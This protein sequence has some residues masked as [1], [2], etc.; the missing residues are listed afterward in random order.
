[1]SKFVKY[2]PCPR[3][4]ERGRDRAGDNLALY[5]DGSKHC[6]SCHLHV[7][8]K[9]YVKPVYE[10]IRTEVKKVLPNDFSR[11]IP[12]TAW[13]WLL[14]Y[15][16]GFRY[17][18][19]FTG[20]SEKESR[21]IFTVG[22]PIDFSVGRYIDG[23]TGTS[24]GV[25]QGEGS[26]VHSVGAKRKWYC[27]GDAHKKA[28]VIGDSSAAESIVLVEDIIS[29]HKVGQVTSSI[30]LFGTNIFEGVL[31]VLKLY[32]KPVIL[33]YDADQKD[34]AVKRAAR[35]SMLTGLPVSYRFT[36]S[37]PKSLSFDEIRNVLNG[38]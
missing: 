16:L 29:A 34:H 12:A 2:E 28:H 30:P 23:G 14:Q 25:R 7:T 26:L 27:Y 11:D 31:P 21:L 6:F 8:P 3:C 33:W 36:N 5:S 18:Q 13:K 4:R 35:L 9:H 17:W 20:Y 15:G 24:S 1:M 22:E 19:P 37:D 38:I 32:K 10:E